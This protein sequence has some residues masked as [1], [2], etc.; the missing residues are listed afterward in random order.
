MGGDRG[1]GRAGLGRKQKRAIGGGRTAAA[2]RKI[3]KKPY[4]ANNNGDRLY[5]LWTEVRI[6]SSSMPYRTGKI[7][8][9]TTLKKTRERNKITWGNV[10]MERTFGVLGL[11]TRRP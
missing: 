3:E 2:A 4:P 10:T 7:N 8:L 11:W 1:G 9:L 5:Y 6:S